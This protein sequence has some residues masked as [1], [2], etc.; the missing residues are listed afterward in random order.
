MLDENSP[1]LKVKDVAKQLNISSDRLRTYDEEKLID[2]MRDKNNNRLY[3]CNDVN[4]L[5]CIRKIISSNT[6]NI[7]I[8]GIKYILSIL[9]F[10][11]DEEFNT[12]MKKQNGDSLWHIFAYMKS[13]PNYEKLRKYYD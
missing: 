6:N 3:S 4:W 5:T 7:S 13:N 8:N 1:I 10:I 12:F 2:P 11:S 9:Y